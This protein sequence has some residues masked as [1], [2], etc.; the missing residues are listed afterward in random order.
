MRSKLDKTLF[1]CPDDYLRIT[2]N[3]GVLTGCGYRKVSY[4]SRLCSSTIYLSYKSPALLSSIY[5]G[6]R[7]YYQTVDRST[8][9]DCSTGTPVPP[10]QQVVT[11]TQ[12][13]LVRDLIATKLMKRTVCRGNETTIDIPKDFN[14]FPINYFYGVTTDFTC[15]TIG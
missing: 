5:R 10:T 3:T 2:D 7:L 15:N 8:Q 13:P 9:P 1:S 6:F 12:A 14:L 4:E 11:T